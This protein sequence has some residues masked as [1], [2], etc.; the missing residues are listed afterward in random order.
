MIEIF[1]DI[2]QR[3]EEWRKIRAGLPTASNFATVLA[4]GKSGPESKTRRDYLL[5][6]A[7]EILTGEP[8][9]S[10]SNGYMDRGGRMEE[11]AKDFYAF[12]HDIEPECVGFIRNGNKG[13]SPD[14]LLG[15]EGL[16]EIKTVA[17]HI[18]IDLILKDEFP[19]K[20]RAQV[21]GQIWVSGREWCDLLC[22][23]TGMPP[24]IKRAYRDPG[25]I[26]QLSD[27]VDQFNEELESV[28]EKI[29]SYGIERATAS[30]GSA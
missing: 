21:Q 6:L 27:A 17:P 20:F 11:E 4:K 15:S 8:M 28:V 12:L 26:I 30:G 25:Y 1:T 18:L 13:C 19:P 2:E 10:Y 23:F 22:Y 3:S 16:L 7:G 29:R 24:L 14:A 9:E 5:K